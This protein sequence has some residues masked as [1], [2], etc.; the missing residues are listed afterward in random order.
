MPTTAR[1][2][3]FPNPAEYLDRENDGDWRHEYVDGVIYATAGGTE[4]HN[5]IVGNLLAHLKLGAP[6]RC[7]VFSLD[8]KLTIKGTARERFYYPDV[9]VT[10]SE[11]DRD[12]HAKSE[13]SLVIEV[14]SPNTC[15]KLQ[16]YRQIPSLLEY[17]LVQQDFPQVDIYRRRRNW[18]C[19]T[20]EP[21]SAITLGSIGVSLTF[22]QVYRQV[23]FPAAPTT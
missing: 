2:V 4:N 17:M 18:E 3:V 12:K 15:E 11:A 10:C 6:V 1:R 14:L 5:L 9:F 13:P 20:L 21:D 19:E 8:M 16:A 22:E 23:E 7:R